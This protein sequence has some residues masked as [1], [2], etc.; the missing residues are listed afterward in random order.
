MSPARA[1]VRCHVA[2]SAQACMVCSGGPRSVVSIATSTASR[3]AAGQHPPLA[4]CVVEGV[5]GPPPA[6]ELDLPF[7]RLSPSARVRWDVP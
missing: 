6:V 5:E 2:S 7:G 4:R 1:V 3:A